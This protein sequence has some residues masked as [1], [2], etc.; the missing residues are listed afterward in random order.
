M[1]PVEECVGAV[2]VDENVEE[3]EAMLRS[4]NGATAIVQQLAETGK[5]QCFQRAPTAGIRGRL[6]E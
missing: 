4:T 5:S 3:A 2:R 1:D 6:E